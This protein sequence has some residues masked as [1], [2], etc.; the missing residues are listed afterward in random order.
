MLLD[1]KR[2]LIE[3]NK[4]N[5]SEEQASL[6]QNGIELKKA[7]A[8]LKESIKNNDEKQLTIK[9]IDGEEATINK[10]TIGKMLAPKTVNKSV[11]NGFAKEQHFAVA[12]DIENL[13]KNS[14]KVLTH[15]HNESN[16]DIKAIHRFVAPIYKDNGVF[17]TVRE[18]TEHGKKIY[19]IELV[20]LGKLEGISNR[21]KSNYTQA[22][23]TSL[24]Y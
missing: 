3:K 1:E 12:S 14:I 5:V 7:V 13:Y 4:K 8:I 9:N 2:A 21:V 15:M 16:L 10:K 23:A 6:Y 19:S 18:L 22:T 20:E 17:I 24:P 11:E